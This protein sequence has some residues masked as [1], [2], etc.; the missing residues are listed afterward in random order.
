MTSLIQLQVCTDYHMFLFSSSDDGCVHPPHHLHQVGIFTLV[1]IHSCIYRLTSGLVGEGG[2]G[3]GGDVHP[4]QL[5]P[6][7]QVQLL[8]GFQ[9]WEKSILRK[10]KK[11]PVLPLLFPTKWDSFFLPL[12]TDS[13]LRL[14]CRFF[15]HCVL[16]TKEVPRTCW[17]HGNV[18]V[19]VHVHRG[20]PLLPHVVFCGDQSVGTSHKVPGGVC[21]VS[22]ATLPPPPSILFLPSFDA[23]VQKNG[24]EKSACDRHWIFTFNSAP[25]VLPLR[26]SRV[27]SYCTL[28]VK[29]NVVIREK[30][31]V[32]GRLPPSCLKEREREREGNERKRK[33]VTHFSCTLL[34][35]L[36][37][38][39]NRWLTCI[40][41]NV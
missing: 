28:S 41:L 26:A 14:T 24:K 19:C 27:A 10:E 38:H 12:C 34:F 7:H 31:A 20:G 21:R 25:A 30:P 35:M 9:E 1:L 36:F 39:P 5:R 29:T 11:Q 15:F 32:C 18:L 13:L 6:A 17:N 3:H 40:I 16:L 23:L 2:C 8:R 4:G 33:P 37:L 22:L